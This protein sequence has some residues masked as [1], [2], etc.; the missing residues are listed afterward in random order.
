MN[1]KKIL[2][3]L[4]LITIVGLFI[5]TGCDNSSKNVNE[6]NVEEV[7]KNEEAKIPNTQVKDLKY[8]IP[9]EFKNYKD[10]IGIAYSQDTRKI[11]VKGNASDLNDA[12]YVDVYTNVSSQGLTNY[13]ENVNKN[14]SDQDV[15]ISFGKDII[16]DK[17]TTSVFSRENFVL[18]KDGNETLNFAYFTYKDGYIYTINIH[19]PNSK[20][21]EIKTLAKEVLSSIKF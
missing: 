17:G 7:Q 8:Y 15:K 5:L 3:L 21:E 13:I 19:G 12:I 9:S 16:L 18:K 14:L 6:K 11:F 2:I 1:K 10:L 4:L 20:S